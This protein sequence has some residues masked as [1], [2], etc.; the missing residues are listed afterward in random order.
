MRW[1]D[2]KNGLIIFDTSGNDI[3]S[4]SNGIGKIISEKIEN[5]V[6]NF[7]PHSNRPI[8]IKIQAHLVNINVIQCYARTV[9]KHETELNAFYNKKNYYLIPRELNDLNNR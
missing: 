4:N 5:A 2:Q 3:V 7:I 9:D 1:S 6:V 8:L